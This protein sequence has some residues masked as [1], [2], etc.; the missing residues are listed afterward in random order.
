[1]N[2]YEYCEYI[3]YILEALDIGVGWALALL[4]PWHERSCT[5]G[6]PQGA[7]RQLK[8]S[9]RGRQDAHEPVAEAHQSLS[10]VDLSLEA[11]IVDEMR[12]VRACYMGLG[13]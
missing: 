4:W 6:R 5:R 13:V 8:M 7:S 10:F 9:C 12:C 11:L 1:M 2:I 3:Y